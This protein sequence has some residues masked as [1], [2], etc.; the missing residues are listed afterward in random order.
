MT[1]PHTVIA[2][3]NHD[4]RDITVPMLELKGFGKGPIKIEDDVWIGANCTITDGVT[5]KKGAVVGANNVVT[6]DVSEYDIVA[7]CPAKVIGNRTKLS[8]GLIKS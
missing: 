5:I 8:S 7:G 3:G 1:G 6:K 2:A 4:Y